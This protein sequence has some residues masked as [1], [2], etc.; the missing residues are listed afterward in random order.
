VEHFSKDELL[1]IL[2]VARSHRERDFL[3]ILVAYLHGLRAS[4]VTQITRDDIEDGYLRVQRLKGSLRTAQPLLEHAEP[5]LNERAA[6]ADYTRN[7][8]GNQRLFPIS[9][10]HFWRLVKKYA[11]L[12]G[13]PGH[14]SFPHA[15]KHSIAMHTIQIAGI[16]NTRQWLGHRS[17]S[18]TGEYLKVS[19]SD[20]ARAIKRALL[21]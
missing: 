11:K 5:L 6:L 8:F 1:A 21:D 20:A 12:A 9:R 14:K 2:R 13:I 4:E 15:L 18:S 17:I 10:V 16:E 7:F 3:L 19:D